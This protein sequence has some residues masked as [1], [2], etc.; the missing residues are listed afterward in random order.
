MPSIQI[1]EKK[2]YFLIRCYNT[3][4]KIDH[5]ALAMKSCT[6]SL[7]TYWG[8]CNIFR[9]SFKCVYK[10]HPEKEYLIS[11]CKFSQHDI[12]NSVTA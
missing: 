8:L 6:C 10:R 11:K 3:K 2:Y 4:V 9:L 5:V 12:L 1:S 7:F